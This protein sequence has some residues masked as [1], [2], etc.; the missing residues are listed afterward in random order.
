MTAVKVLPLPVAIWIRERGRLSASDVSRLWTLSIW[1]RHR[2]S[3]FS[4]GICRSSA[5]HLLV[6]LD[7]ADQLFGPVEGEDFPAAGVR[8]QGVGELRDGPRWIRRRTAAAGGNAAGSAGSPSRY[9][10]DCVS[11]PVRVCPSGLASTTPM[12]LPSA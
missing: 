7:Q 8:L 11:T 4:G 1:T 2:R 3:V 5:A 6:E 10:P 12:A 9:L